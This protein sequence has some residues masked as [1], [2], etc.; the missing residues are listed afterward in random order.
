MTTFSLA[1]AIELGVVVLF[2][3]VLVAAIA[4]PLHRLLLALVAVAG[5]RVEALGRPLPA[6][7]VVLPPP[8]VDEGPD[9][10][11]Q[12]LMPVERLLAA[13]QHLEVVVA[14]LD[15]NLTVLN[16]GA[17]SPAVQVE[18][19]AVVAARPT[20]PAPVEQ[21]AVEPA[22][23]DPVESQRL[24]AGLC[25][26]AVRAVEGASEQS[27][28]NGARLTP[29]EKHREACR[30]VRTRL[31]GFVPM[32]AP[33]TIDAKQVSLAIEAAAAKAFPKRR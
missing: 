15:Q 6:P 19:V 26:E 10:A 17:S 14:R 22:Y 2:A 8:V 31:E 25:D 7:P 30:V 4:V 20:P 21:P 33:S 18:P 27:R 29:A 5:A 11:Q 24:L 16:A 23:L 9:I 13:L 32:P 28:A 12:F 3:G 1:V